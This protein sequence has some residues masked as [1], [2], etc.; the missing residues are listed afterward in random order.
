M[1]VLNRSEK[2][3]PNP[4]CCS[5]R[6]TM[7][8]NCRSKESGMRSN[9]RRRVRANREGVLDLPEMNFNESRKPKARRKL[10]S[11]EVNRNEDENMLDLPE[12]D[13]SSRR[14]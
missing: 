5:D 12:M 6:R 2:E 3:V 1:V 13:F 8:G 4:S 14:R 10:R 9:R 11:V 7:C